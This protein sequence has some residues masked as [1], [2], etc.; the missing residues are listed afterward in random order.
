M[1]M[2]Q[3]YATVKNNILLSVYLQTILNKRLTMFVKTAF[4]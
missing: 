2:G 3:R 4:K 1:T